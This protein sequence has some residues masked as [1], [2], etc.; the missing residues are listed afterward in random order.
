MQ[1]NNHELLLSRIKDLEKK[2]QHLRISRRVLMSLV[3]RQEQD[4][5]VQILELLEENRRLRRTNNRFAQTLW[6]KN[7]QIL[8]LTLSKKQGNS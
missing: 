2:V 4:K 1:E 7:R 6:L 8:E 3:T 5:A